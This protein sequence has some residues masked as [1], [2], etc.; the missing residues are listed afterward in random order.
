MINDP[1]F[2]LE[3][4]VS[5]GQSTP[6]GQ[7][8]DQEQDEW[9]ILLKGSAGLSLEEGS[10]TIV[11]KPGDHLLLPARQKHRVEWTDE[12]VPTIWLALHFQAN[13]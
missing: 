6:K 8:Y 10:E 4:I 9:V 11:L 3:R 13:Q 5:H 7:W 12:K 1:S 2:R